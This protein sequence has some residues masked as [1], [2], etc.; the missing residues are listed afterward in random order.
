MIFLDVLF[1]FVPEA[2]VPG[3]RTNVISILQINRLR[4]RHM[5]QMLLSHLGDPR[6]L[7]DEHC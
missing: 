1:S 7:Q 2:N 6:Y 5:K 3:F 4:L